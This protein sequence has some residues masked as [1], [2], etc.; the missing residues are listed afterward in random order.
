MWPKNSRALLIVT[1]PLFSRAANP[2]LGHFSALLFSQLPGAR[3]GTL[4]ASCSFLSRSLT[5]ISQS[6]GFGVQERDGGQVSSR[7]IWEGEY[8]RAL[9]QHSVRTPRLFAGFRANPVLQVCFHFS[10][11][12]H[13]SWPRAAAAV[14][15]GT[16][17]WWRQEDQE[18]KVNLSYIV[19][20]QPSLHE[21][22]TKSHYEVLLYKLS[23]R[24]C[25]R[26]CFYCCVKIRVA[27]SDFRKR[28]F[29]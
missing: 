14:L 19:K 11:H 20:G 21:E 10:T 15:R 26:C 2:P 24:C 8:A 25:L 29:H 9:G 27:K 7:G 28:G 6:S 23:D 5:F 4:E 12:T 3:L 16:S 1:V 22:E 17:S 13:F 18:F